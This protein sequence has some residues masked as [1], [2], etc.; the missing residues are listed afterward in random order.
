MALNRCLRTPVKTTETTKTESRGIEVR[1][2]AI[3]I[4]GLGTV[5]GGTFNLILKNGDEIARKTGVQLRVSHVGSRRDN[6]DCDVSQT[7]VSR[8]VFAVVQDPEVEV[9]LELMGGTDTAKD[10]VEQA[11]DNGKHVVTAN[12]ALIALHGTEL[13]QRAS[14]NNVCLRFEAAIAGGI[15]IVKA[16]TEGLAGN[17]NLFV[18]GIINGTTNYILT[19]MEQ[20]GN[21][22]FSEVLVEAQ[23][24]GYAEADPTFDVEG[25]DAAHKLTILSSMAFGVPLNFSAM[26]TEGISAITSADIKYAAELGYRIKHLGITRKTDSGIELRVHPTLIKKT[27]MLAQVN[28]VMNAVLVGSDA[29][30]ETMYVGAGAGAGPTASSVLT[31]V[32]DIV[33][34]NTTS[35]LGYQLDQISALPMLAMDDIVSAYYL[36]LRVIDVPGVM[37]R[38]STILSQGNIS[39][40]SLI[41]K[42]VRDGEV[43]IVIVTNDVQEQNLNAA[44]AEI[45]AMEQIKGKVARIR[46]ENI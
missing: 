9:V 16:L 31:D 23:K 39:I 37:A 5:G 4:C 12:K 8:D 10:L 26:Y 30:G 25:I 7:K 38:V 44:I 27:A 43:P 18:A 40:E 2:V 11:I 20:A 45:E 28:G 13:M 36:R 46:V 22:D 21:R 33:Q 19:E 6:P 29:A 24:L 3:G 17:Q 35:G 32:I 41:Q 42:D 14:D 15:P 1:E 34:G